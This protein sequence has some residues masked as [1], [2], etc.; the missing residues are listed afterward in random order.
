MTVLF[1]GKRYLVRYN[2]IDD[3]ALTVVAFDPA[4]ESPSPMLGGE[5]FAE[6]FLRHQGINALGV[7]SAAN[8][9]FQ[10]A[11]MDEVIA[12]IRAAVP[13]GQLIGYGASMGGYAAINF[14]ADIGLSS[15]IAIAP[16]FSPDPA[17]VPFDD[18]WPELRQG[19]AFAR[20]HVARIP[21][22]TCG[23]IICDPFTEDGAHARLIAAHHDLVCVPVTFSGHGALGV[24]ARAGLSEPVLLDMLNNTFDR[25]GFVRQLRERRRQDPAI[26]REAGHRQAARNR[27]VWAGIAFAEAERLSSSDVNHTYEKELADQYQVDTRIHPDDD[28]YRYI[29]GGHPDERSAL[30][31]YV[32]DGRRS[33]ERLDSLVTTHLGHTDNQISLLEFASGYGCLSRHFRNFAGRYQVVAC[34]IHQ[35]A[36]DFLQGTLGVEAVPSNSDPDMLAIDQT[37][38]VVFALSFFSHIP[39]GT[40]GRWLAKLL[41]L[42]REGGL[43]IFTTHG[44][45]GAG[46]VGDPSLDRDGFWFLLSSEQRDLPV[47]EYGTMFVTPSYAFEQLG[48]LPHARPVWFQQA[49]WWGTQDTYV[50]RRIGVETVA[51]SAKAVY[52]HM[53]FPTL[54]SQHLADARIFAARDDM[55]G[56]LGI[57]RNGIIA[58]VGVG[59]GWFSRQLVDMLRPARF[60]AIDTFQLHTLATIWGRPTTDVF[61]ARTHREYY[62]G[63]MQDAPC[64]VSIDAG[65]SHECLAAYPDGYFD[66][67][68]LDCD[69]SYESVK[70]DCELARRK[71]SHDGVLVLNDYIMFDH[72]AGMPYGVVPAANEL[73]VNGDWKVIGFALQQHMFC[74]IALR[75]PKQSELPHERA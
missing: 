7:K 43:L 53:D 34:D 15:V 54:S 63:I 32:S 36:V 35:L 21:R 48:R 14:S 29:R 19:Y 69:H 49:F 31:Y 8:D 17:K 39:P 2:R 4:V 67:I 58:E 70:R 68:Y 55:L 24:L 72:L 38:D 30:T 59:I 75:P 60:V 3:S 73:I 71:L 37:F 25:D 28:I 52:P 27:H 51:L 64:T 61:G 18:R 62:E 26:W 41:S 23:Y 20:D 66:L 65:L 22:L 42:V 47:S 40:W 57:R 74:D 13:S 11:E 10:H 45:V 56:C 16:Q 44:R 9:W 6:S 50:V 5:F 1:S 33:V 46:D 12:V